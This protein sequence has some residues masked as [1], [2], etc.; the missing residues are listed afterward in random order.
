MSQQ[1]EFSE[2]ELAA[3]RATYCPGFTD[4][5]FEVCMTF[6]RVRNLLPGKHVIFSLRS[7]KEWDEA[8]Q[9][10]VPVTKIIFM[11]TI[12]A[13]RLIAERTKLYNGQAP[14]QYIYLDDN[15]APSIISE[16]P[17]PQLPLPPK[18]TAA[19]PREPWAVKTTVYRK[20]FSQPVS[21]IARFDAYAATY[22]TKEGPKLS[23]MWARRG[24]EQLAKCSE[25]LSLRKAFPEELGGI[26]IAEEL[27]PDAEEVAT[28]PI[29]P[30]V[31]VPLP[32]P[33]PKVN[34]TPAQ[35]TEAPRPNM[36]VETAKKIVEALP[37]MEKLLESPEIQK[38]LA[39]EGKKVDH[40]EISRIK[41]Q[42]AAVLAANPSVKPAAEIP[43]P[44][45]KKGR[46]S[47]KT[48]ESPDNGSQQPTDQGITQADIEDAQKPAPVVDQAANKAAAEAF[49][50]SVTNFTS[51]EAAAAGL[52]EPPDYSKLPEGKQLTDFI[53]RVRALPEPGA[54][55]KDLGDYMLWLSKKVGQPSKNMTVGDWNRALTNMEAAK[56]S[57]TLKELVKETGNVPLPAF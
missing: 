35:P 5:Q 26:Y 32:P 55:I 16:I 45:K 28:Q 50:D 20:D 21:S 27:K 57:G 14:E 39:E 11:T 33:V 9:A 53:A 12:D 22:N 41:E 38:K 48:A 15:G 8:A 24:P 10:K 44:P 37:I 1:L 29:S 13:S 23:E 54:S 46:P 52:P 2:K 31:A 51:I 43:T 56:K 7:S 25:M 34:Q 49:V 3:I 47:K 42:A 4:Q 6:C 40:E 17:L 19:L 30:A 18:G 36:P